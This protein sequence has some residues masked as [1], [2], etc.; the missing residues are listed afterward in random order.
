MR[1]AD[2]LSRN[3]IG[4]LRCA[5]FI[6]SGPRSPTPEAP[7]TYVTTPRFLSASDWRHCDFRTSRRLRT[8]VCW[9]DIRFQSKSLPDGRRKRDGWGPILFWVTH[10][11]RTL[12]G[13]R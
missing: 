12:K 1:L 5:G 3:T 6:G 2:G 8:P 9:A 11:R 10:P 7:Y 4:A 13:C